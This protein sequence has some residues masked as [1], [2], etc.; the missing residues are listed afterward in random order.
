[1][2]LPYL[3]FGDPAFELGALIAQP[4]QASLAQFLL[5]CFWIQKENVV[6]ELPFSK[7]SFDC[8]KGNLKS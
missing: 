7:L 6:K 5:A 3:L 8:F 2:Q 4:F 1:M